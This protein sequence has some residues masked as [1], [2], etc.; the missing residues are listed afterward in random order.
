[1]IR[2]LLVGVALC[3][4]NP[5]L[6]R[7]EARTPVMIDIPAGTFTMGAGEELSRDY[8]NERP[9]HQVTISQPFKIAAQEVTMAEWRYFNRDTVKTT[10]YAPHVAGI[11]WNDAKAYAEWLSKKTGRQFRL[12]TEAEWEYVARLVDKDPVGYRAIKG[13]SSGPVEWTA[14]IFGPYSLAAQTD[15]TGAATGPLR[16]AR[17]GRMGSNPT[18]AGSDP[19]IEID[20]TRPEARLAFPPSFAPYP[21]AE[22]GGGFHAIGLRLVEGPAPTTAPI[23]VTP[24]LHSAGVRQDLA[25]AKMGPDPSKP[26]FRRRT[27]LPY[28]PDH[29]GGATID[30]TGWDSWLRNHHHSPGITVMPNG[31]VLIAIYTSY[32]EYEAGTSILATRLRHGADEWD[33]P[34]Q[35]ADIVGVND[36]APLLMRD[37]K[38]VRFFWGNPYSGYSEWG[39]KGFPFQTM[40]T[41]DNGATWSAITYPKVVGPIRG[42]NRQ[43]INTAF[44]DSKGRLLLSSDGAADVDAGGND[45]VSLLWASD[46]DGKTW[47]DT[48]GRTFGRHTTFVEAKDGRILGFGGKNTNIDDMM[49]LSTSTDGGKTYTQSKLPF[50]ALSSAQRPTIMRLQSG[51][52]M[53]IGDYVKTKPIT[54]PVPERGAYVA[55]STDEGATWKF[56]PLPGT[57]RSHNTQRGIDMQGGTVGYSAAAQ[58]PDGVIHL[59]TSVGKHSI[60]LAFNEAWID[61]P[62]GALP[63][64]AVLERNDV[65]SVS[66]VKVHQ[67]RYP[68]GKLR[69]RWSGG[70]AN[71]GAIVFDGPQRWFH[72]NGKPQ[73]EAEYRLGRKVGM[74]KEYDVSGRLVS[75]REHGADGRSTWTRWWPNGQLRSVSGWKGVAADGRARTWAADGK[76]L[77][78]VTFVDGAIPGKVFK[79]GGYPLENIQ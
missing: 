9:A 45:N 68:D 28:P 70:R 62:Q 57:D 30:K 35:F 25:T 52:L 31:D 61:S 6:A 5:A 71:N 69:G 7:Q 36:H 47:Y 17:G 60:A 8:F 55:I 53:M 73:W 20:Y 16:V 29:T 44:R 66:G 27:Y 19:D 64:N 34:S 58:G 24:P 74:E 14:D 79:T 15:P 13:M 22:R 76:L 1:M 3:A 75:Q 11:S 37:G 39:D 33:A 4:I 77:S 42:H 67:E 32:R 65:T 2:S 49:P 59:V 21:G 54:R 51:R 63:D 56:R 18:R 48:G 23:A 41:S 10:D 46:D 72:P 26:Y 12:P 50:V 43:P 40:S 38:D 78:D